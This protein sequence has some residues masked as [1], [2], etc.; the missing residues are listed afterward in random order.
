M[1]HDLPHVMMCPSHCATYIT[2][3][4][5]VVVCPLTPTVLTLSISQLR[6]SEH[7]LLA[8]TRVHKYI[9]LHLLADIKCTGAFIASFLYTQK[10]KW[11]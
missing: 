6:W 8:S 9:L 1:F 11:H 10:V 3:A 7:D 4:A 2:I 5:C